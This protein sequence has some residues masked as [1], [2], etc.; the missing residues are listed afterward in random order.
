MSESAKFEVGDLVRLR[1][2]NYVTLVVDDLLQSLVDGKKWLFCSGMIGRG[3]G[4]HGATL[5]REHQL[6]KVPEKVDTA[7]K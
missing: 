3:D 1:G 7:A 4:M 2:N 6:E 5:L